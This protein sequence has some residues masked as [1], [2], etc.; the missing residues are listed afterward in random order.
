MKEWEEL[1]AKLGEMAPIM[2]ILLEHE[3]ETAKKEGYLQGWDERHKLIASMDRKAVVEE[4]IKIVE[5]M[6]EPDN[7][8][9]GCFVAVKERAIEKLKELN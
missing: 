3:R 9:F 2:D 7:T 8:E 6:E 5:D 1:Y 4:A